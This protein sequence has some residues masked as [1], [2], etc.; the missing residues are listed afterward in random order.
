MSAAL[1]FDADDEPIEMCFYDQHRFACGDW[2]W[3]HFKQHCNREYRTGETCGMK[4]VMQTY[5]L[6]MKCKT[7]EKIDTKRRRLQHEQER[8][9]RWA[10]EPN[11]YSA[12]IEKAV[13]SINI[14]NGEI[15]T[16]ECERQRRSQA[17]GHQTP[18]SL[19]P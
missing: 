19:A 5:G 14:L 13:E 9:Q 10:R 1:P 12:S 17:I 2:K 11:K 6:Q 16:L 3:G 7:C 8:L 4:L 15:Y 18:H